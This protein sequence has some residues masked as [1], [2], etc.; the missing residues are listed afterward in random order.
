MGVWGDD[1]TL[2]ESKVGTRAAEDGDKGYTKN[3]T[4]HPIPSHPSLKD[5][6]QKFIPAI[7]SLQRVG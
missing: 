7:W 4:S 3:S 6:S 5:H 1:L 2:F